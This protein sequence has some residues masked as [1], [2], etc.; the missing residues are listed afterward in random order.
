MEFYE[1]L[2]LKVAAYTWNDQ[3]TAEQSVSSMAEKRQDQVP[4]S[5]NTQEPKKT[6]HCLHSFAYASPYQLKWPWN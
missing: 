6:Q 1:L 4:D 3:C 2:E 5:I